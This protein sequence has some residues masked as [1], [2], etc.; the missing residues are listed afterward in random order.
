[1]LKQEK[2]KQTEKHEPVSHQTAQKEKVFSP[3]SVPG[4]KWNGCSQLSVIKKI[5]FLL[6][7][8]LVLIS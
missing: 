8:F 1:M 3:I 2:K 5:K 4:E 7:L 6:Q